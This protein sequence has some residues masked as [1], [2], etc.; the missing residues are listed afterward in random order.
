MRGV[1]DIHTMHNLEWFKA[2]ASVINFCV[3]DV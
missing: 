1:I 3:T 2:Q